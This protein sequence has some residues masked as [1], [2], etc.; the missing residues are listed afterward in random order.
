MWRLQLADPKSGSYLWTSLTIHNNALYAGVSSLGDCPL[1]RGALVRIDL[2]N[3]RQP[4][5]GLVAILEKVEEPKS[6]DMT[7]RRRSAAVTSPKP[8]KRQSAANEPS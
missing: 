8:P 2:A 3:P 6:S 5:K 7:T 4:L 1:V